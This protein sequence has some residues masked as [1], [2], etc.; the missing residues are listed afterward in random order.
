MKLFAVVDRFEGDMAVLYVDKEDYMLNLPKKFLP[1]HICEGD[2]VK[3]E[4]TFDAFATLFRRREM[5]KKMDD[6]FQ[7]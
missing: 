4:I 7:D 5:Q 2:I 1:E 6:I 3:L